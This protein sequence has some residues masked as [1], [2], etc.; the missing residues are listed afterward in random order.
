MTCDTCKENKPIKFRCKICDARF[1]SR[2]CI[3]THVKVLCDF[4]AMKMIEEIK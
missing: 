1:C 2:E 4:D 3:E